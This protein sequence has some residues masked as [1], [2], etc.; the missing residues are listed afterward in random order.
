MT[1]TTRRN[2]TFPDDLWEAVMKAAA[3]ETLRTGQRIT[4]SEWLREAARQRLERRE[5]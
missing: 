5:R 1:D 2:V 4:A 3:K